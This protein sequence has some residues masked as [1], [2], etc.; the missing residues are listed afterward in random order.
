MKK[1][2]IVLSLVSLVAVSADAQT[3]CNNGTTKHKSEKSAVQ[4][5]AKT[6]VSPFASNYKVCKAVCGYSICNEAPTMYNTAPR[7]CARQLT[8]PYTVEEYDNINERQQAQNPNNPDQGSASPQNQSYKNIK[9][10][11]V[12]NTNR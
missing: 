1:L 11:T 8:G 9:N 12:Q 4:T 7:T 5:T 2:L 3:K 6:G 10:S